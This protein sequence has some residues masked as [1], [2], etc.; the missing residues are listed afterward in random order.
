MRISERW[1]DL[2][3]PIDLPPESSVTSSD[4]RDNPYGWMLDDQRPT[5]TMAI[6]AA[7]AN[8]PVSRVLVGM[9][10]YGSS[11]DLNTFQVRA[12]FELAGIPAGQNLAPD[13]R[14][15]APGIWELKLP[16]PLTISSGTLMI[17]IKDRQA[18]SQ[19][20]NGAFLL[21]HEG[22]M[23]SPD[24]WRCKCTCGNQTVVRQSSLR[25]G[26]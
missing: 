15:A 1:I 16:S 18:M 2:G 9:H 7:G 10:D 12:D 6:P 23:A 5:L 8:P 24:R 11:L 3:C 4:R 19:T 17:S 21:G 25:S 26:A 13:F 22:T 20:S 14:S